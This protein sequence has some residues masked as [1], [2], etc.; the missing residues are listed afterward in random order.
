MRMDLEFGRSLQGCRLLGSCL[1]DRLPRR[2]DHG[3]S[4][5]LLETPRGSGIERHHD[6]P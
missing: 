6:A 4:R 1:P 2:P 3:L 5:I